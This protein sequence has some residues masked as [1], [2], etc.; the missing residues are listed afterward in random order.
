[1]DPE[2]VGFLMMYLVIGGIISGAVGWVATE[3]GR[4]G[5]GWFFLSLFLSPIMAVLL[6]IACPAQK[7]VVR[8]TG[9][10]SAASTRENL[11]WLLDSLPVQTTRETPTGVTVHRP[12]AYL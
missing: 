2:F 8:A 3:K 11:D 10:G 9:V 6:L 12:D 7:K 5:Y 4:S 1:M